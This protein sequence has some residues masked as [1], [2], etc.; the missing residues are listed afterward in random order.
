MPF[1]KTHIIGLIQSYPYIKQVIDKGGTEYSWVIEILFA[2]EGGESLPFD[3]HVFWTK[4]PMQ[5]AE[6]SP[7]H[8]F[9]SDLIEY[10][11]IMLDG[12]VCLHT[13]QCVTWDD[14]IKAEIEAVHQWI[15][16]YYTGKQARDEHYEELV[17][18]ASPVRGRVVQFYYT[19]FGR[20]PQA[21]DYGKV[22]YSQLA[23]NTIDDKPTDTYIVNE[24]VWANGDKS[25]CEWSS[26][27]Q[28][29]QKS[30]GLF[31]MLNGCP[32]EHK[33]F[34]CST[35]DELDGLCKDEQ[36]RYLY[37]ILYKEKRN[38]PIFWGYTTPKG[39]LRWLVTYPQE[40]FLA[41]NKQDRGKKHARPRVLSVM[42]P[43]VDS[44]DISYEHFFGR[45]RF[46]DTIVQKKI[47]LFG[48]G[49]LGSGLATALVRGGIKL[50]TLCDYDKKH[51]GNVC[52]SEYIFRSGL[53][54]KEIELKTI[55]EG[56]SPFVE[57][58]IDGKL[59]VLKQFS[60]S[61]KE[62]AQMILN[63]YDLIFDC[64]VDGE[65]MWTL[66]QLHLSTPVVSLSISNG[67]KDIV[68]AFSP[69]I[70]EFVN[71]V[72]QNA[73]DANDVDLFNPE[74][75]WS[76]TFKASYNDVQIMLQ[77]ALR[78]AVKMLSGEIEKKNFMVRE[79]EDAL[80]IVRW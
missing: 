72:S 22:K 17:I 73:V 43:N 21:G 64:T 37:R 8:F 27:Y 38:V 46:P 78:Y 80:Q 7:V 76:P 58:E 18:E 10:P 50:I 15:E 29:G 24:I 49:A 40:R 14:R 16:L 12:H 26:A 2:I 34:A 48:V 6:E 67:A 65:L 60:L 56:I 41:E 31:V 33:K 36:W 13:P 66:E 75:C 42:M 53:T 68:C 69:H 71:Y 9:N 79:K 55:L 77:Y 28:L 70:C 19:Q 23:A 30:E 57:V 5:C 1:D 35:Y 32:A 45:G 59:K 51:P 39:K 62:D 44:A 54:N 3:M 47:L 61:N 52:R 63:E 25:Q 4:S 11:H 74:G 20:M